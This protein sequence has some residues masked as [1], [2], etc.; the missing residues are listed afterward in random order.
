MGITRRD[1]LK[2]SGASTLAMATGLGLNPQAAKAEGEVLKLDGSTKLPSICHFCAS[3]CGMLLHIKE[4]K[5]IYLEGDPDHPINEGALCPKAASLRHVAYSEERIVKPLRRAPGSDHWEDISWEEA[6]SKIASKIQDVRDS[7]W[8]ATEEYTD[9]SGNKISA[10]VNRADGL[11]FVGCA[12]VDNEESY[13]ITKLSRILGIPYNEHQARICHAPSVSALAPPFGRGAMTNSFPDM[14]HTKVFLIAGSNCAEAHPIAMKWVNRARANGAKVIVVDP[15]FTRTA[16]QADV[17]AQIRPGTDIAYL[18]AMI[19]YIL[20]EKLYDEEFV[21]KSSNALYKINKDYKFEDGLFSGF[22]ETTKKYSMDTWTYQLD[23]NNKPI[24]ASSLDDPDCVFAKLKQHYEPYT[25]ETASE[26]TGIPVEKIKEIADLY[27]KTKPGSIF[28][29]LGMTQHTTGVQGIRAYSVIQLLLGNIGKLGT[30]IQ[31]L[32]GEPNVQGSTD[33]AN[34]FHNLPGYIPAPVH[35]DKTLKHFVARAGKAQEKPMIALLKAW[36]GEH[37][38]AENDY[39]FNYLPKYNANENYYF[40]RLYELMADG[41]FKFMLNV[42]SNSLVSIANRQLV[43]KALP[44]LEMMVVS[45][46]FEVETAQFWR[47]PGVNPAD[48]QT[49]V[50]FLPAAFVY[51]KDGTLTNAGRWIQWKDA[52]ILPKGESKPDLDI[53]DHLYK[54]IKQLYSGSTDPKDAPI[55]NAHWDYGDTPSALKVLEELGGYDVT[56]GK[57]TTIGEYLSAPAGTIATGCWVYAGVTSNG[58]LAARRNNSDPSGLGIFPEWSYSWP[59]NIRI[60]YNRASCDAQGKP[61]DPN[62]KLIWWDEAKGTWTGNDNPDIADKSKAPGTPE[63]DQIF[64]MN[65]EGVSRLFTTK[66]TS[67][68]PTEADA[69]GLKIGNRSAFTCVDGPLPAFYEPTES[70]VTNLLY[71]KHSASPTAIVLSAHPDIQKHGSP[72]DFPYVLTTYAVVEQFCAGGITRNI[73]VLNELMPEPFAEIS[74]NLAAKI[75]AKNGDLV[76]LSSARGKLNVKCMVTDRLQTYKVHGQDTETIGM[77]YSWGFASLSPGPS[78]NELTVGALD[79]GAGTPE[80]KVCLVNI[81]RA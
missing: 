13:L 23:E 12:E 67:G 62:I 35:T 45:D 65:P 56:S 33:M 6:I 39:C 2:L 11:V 21:L 32:R 40:A 31:A 72:A 14:Q 15:R 46:L 51:E 10:Q 63:G 36:F 74:K 44:K 81:R 8:I 37:A 29:A 16:S 47:E 58:N 42:G 28:Y 73:P 54:E 71:P 53:L 20:D 24:L 43:R 7:S 4:K 57:K 34:L 5:F 38:T 27:C 69:D 60:L 76:E 19:K 59:G 79:P 66:Y 70:P 9:S 1:F 68:V 22:N 18:G 49:E 3:G 50:I 61:R 17:F 30:G 78:V 64:R 80:T 25:F 55:L 77:P 52:A 26:I 41:Q 75:G 48:I